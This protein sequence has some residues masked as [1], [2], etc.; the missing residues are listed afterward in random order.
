MTSRL[1]VDLEALPASLLLRFG[2]IFTVNKG[3]LNT[4][5]A[6]T[7]PLLLTATTLE[8]G[9][10][11]YGDTGRWVKY[12]TRLGCWISSC[13]GPFSLEARFETYEPFISLIFLFCFRA[14][15][16]GG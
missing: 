1:L 16:N 2:A 6:I 8:A 4:N 10:R 12:W 15:V 9:K 5:T 11:G 13:Y 14:A 7:Q 3:F